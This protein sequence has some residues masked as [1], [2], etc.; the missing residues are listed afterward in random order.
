[1]SSSTF[2]KLGSALRTGTI[3]AIVVA[4]ISV[5]ALI[6]GTIIVIVCI[7][8]QSNRRRGI[9]AQGRVIQEPQPCAYPPSWSQQYP[10][11]ITSVANYPSQQGLNFSPYSG[12]T[13][14]Y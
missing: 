7:V 2:N 3:I 1:M 14:T 10:P 11:N 9:A 13:T 5:I 8:K 6:I 4:S 12:S